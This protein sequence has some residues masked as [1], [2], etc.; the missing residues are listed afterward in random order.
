[1]VQ[2]TANGN[3][4]HF[5]SNAMV[6]LQGMQLFGPNGDEI[7][8]STGCSLRINAIDFGAAVAAQIHLTKG[9]FGQTSGNY[10]VSGSAF[11][12]VW[13]ESGEACEWVTSETLS[14][15]CTATGPT[16]TISGTPAF[17]SF[18]RIVGPGLLRSRNTTFMNAGSATGGR[19]LITDNGVLSTA[20]GGALV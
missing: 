6:T 14:P 1:S 10:T 12:H 13:I 9:G 11:D 19:C 3:A 7:R 4:T 15:C 20:T 5:I 8:C 16:I 17:T 2:I 18:V